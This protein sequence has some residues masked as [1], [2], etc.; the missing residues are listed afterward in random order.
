MNIRWAVA[1][2]AA[3]SLGA[4]VAGA[5]VAPGSAGSVTAPGTAERFALGTRMT[6]VVLTDGDAS[7]EEW[8][9]SELEEQQD[10]LPTGLF[11]QWFFTPQVGV[12]VTWEKV[13]ADTITDT[14][15]QH[16]DGAFE[17]HGV[18]LQ[19][20]GRWPVEGRVTPFGGLGLGFYLGDFEAE[21]WWRYGYSSKATWEELGS[22]STPR[23]GVE[24]EITTNDPIGWV[25]TLG[26][27]IELAGGWD[28]DLLVR[29]VGVDIEAHYVRYV[30]GHVE[31]D[32]PWEDVP[33]DHLSFCAGVR[34][35]F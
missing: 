5:A 21:T 17:I 35:R 22:P 15:D 19:L 11:A 20:L 25:A 16:S 10:Y 14:A 34:R 26:A 31:K 23:H 9:I 24:R 30:E 13:V 8:T 7:S 18:L 2:A 12:E 33:L 4:A 3:V 27:D 1:G 29:Y 6:H 32:H 28:L